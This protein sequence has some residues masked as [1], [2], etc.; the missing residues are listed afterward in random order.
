MQNHPV[1]DGK[2]KNKRP[3]IDNCVP[4]VILAA[5]LPKHLFPGI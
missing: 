5:L 4:A 1:R 2:G 3:A